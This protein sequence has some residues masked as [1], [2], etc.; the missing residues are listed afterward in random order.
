MLFL[1]SSHCVRVCLCVLP[2][3]VRMS[4]VFS[5]GNKTYQHYQ[6]T[7]RKMDARMALLGAERIF[8]RGEGDDD[9]TYVRGEG[10][11]WIAI[12]VYAHLCLSMAAMQAGG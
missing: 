11:R 8:E 12:A 5:L 1:L 4:Q 10:K 9:G 2:S 3:V 7:G 6:A